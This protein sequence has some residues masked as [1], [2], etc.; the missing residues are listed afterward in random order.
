MAQTILIAEDDADIRAVLRLYL[1]SEGYTVLEAPDGE[2]ALQVALVQS[3]DAAILDVMMPKMNGYELTQALRRTSDIPVLTG[4]FYPYLLLPFVCLAVG[5]SVGRR[6]GPSLFC[7]LFCG[8]LTI[9]CVVFLYNASALFQA[10]VA[11]AFALAGNLA[12]ALYRHLKERGA[13]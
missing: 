5:W 10:G 1:E 6:L 9:P 11:A 8:L 13:A 12:G 7:P 4:L 2:R 3:P